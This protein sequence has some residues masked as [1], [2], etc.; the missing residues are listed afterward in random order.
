MSPAEPLTKI[1]NM[2][3]I[4][5]IT[6]PIPPRPSVKI[7]HNNLIGHGGFGGMGTVLIPEIFLRSSIY[8]HYIMPNV[9]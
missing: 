1:L 5:I 7:T 6:P 3:K 4:M 9:L 2:G 8:L